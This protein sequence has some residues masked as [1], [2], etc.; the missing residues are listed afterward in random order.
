MPHHLVWGWGRVLFLGG[1]TSSFSAQGFAAWA[2]SLKI[3]QKPG[4][5]ERERRPLEIQRRNKQRTIFFSGFCFWTLE[6]HLLSK[7]PHAQTCYNQ[8]SGEPILLQAPSELLP[9]TRRSG[10]TNF[11][12]EVYRGVHGHL[13]SNFRIS[14]IPQG[15]RAWDL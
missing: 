7:G 12:S 13:T 5:A 14:R 6:R 2:G 4:T 3:F 11:A 1:V 15:K 10:R 8:Q 9:A